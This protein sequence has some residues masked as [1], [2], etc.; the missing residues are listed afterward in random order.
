MTRKGFFSYLKSHIP[1]LTSKSGAQTICGFII[2]SSL[3]QQRGM[4]I[5]NCDILGEKKSGN[6]LKLI[7][8]FGLTFHKSRVFFQSVFSFV[9]DDYN[10]SLTHFSCE[11]NTLHLLKLFYLILHRAIPHEI[12]SKKRDARKY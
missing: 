3:S 4:D 10:L 8:K 1:E 9:S 6:I 12:R 7:S 5:A 2:A 11:L